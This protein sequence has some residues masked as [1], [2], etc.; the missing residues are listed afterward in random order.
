MEFENSV[1]IF[2]KIL[3]SADVQAVI[4]NNKEVNK[5]N[6]SVLFIGSITFPL[7][8]TLNTSYT[9]GSGYGLVTPSNAGLSLIHPS[10][11][12]GYGSTCMGFVK[13]NS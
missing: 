12:D 3:S 13:F 5:I 1:P 8:Q 6:K 9:H 10:L 4:K 2:C 7:L 11:G